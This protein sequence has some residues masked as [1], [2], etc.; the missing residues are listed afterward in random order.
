MTLPA[1]KNDLLFTALLAVPK[2][3]SSSDDAPSGTPVRTFNTYFHQLGDNHYQRPSPSATPPT[4][5]VA[6]N[7]FRNQHPSAYVAVVAIATPFGGT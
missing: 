3:L 4:D 6:A 5:T 2:P 7:D 1:A